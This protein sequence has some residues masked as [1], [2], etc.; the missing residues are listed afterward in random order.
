LGVL[1][2]SAQGALVLAL[3]GRAA[4]FLYIL[5]LRTSRFFLQ[6]LSI[7]N[8]AAMNMVEQVSLWD[9]YTSFGYMPMSGIAG[10]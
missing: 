7:M 6:F 1:R 4:L 8:K 2:L 10:S 5:Q 9:V 3:T